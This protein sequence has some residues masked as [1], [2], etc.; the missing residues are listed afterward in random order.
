MCVDVVEKFI[1]RKQGLDQNVPFT[2]SV[3][4]RS[5]ELPLLIIDLQSVIWRKGREK[6]TVL[7]LFKRKHLD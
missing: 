2:L 1:R 7:F 5:N 4:Q 6:Q 3:H